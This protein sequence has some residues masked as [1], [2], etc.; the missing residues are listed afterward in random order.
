ML[1][2]ESGKKWIGL[3]KPAEWRWLRERDDSPWYS[4]A[5]LFRQEGPGG[6]GPVFARM[7]DA[8]LQRLEGSP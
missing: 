7:T 2:R 8:V 3:P 4:T 5:R 1:E 6:W